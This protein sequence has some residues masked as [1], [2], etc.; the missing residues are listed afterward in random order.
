[1]SLTIE[2]LAQNINALND[3]EQSSKLQYRYIQR[4]NS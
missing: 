3:I 1:M 2:E 4:L